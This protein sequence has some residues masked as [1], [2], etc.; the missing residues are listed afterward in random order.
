MNEQKVK[1]VVGPGVRTSVSRALSR[2]RYPLSYYANRYFE[3]KIDTF[4]P[5]YFLV[6]L[7]LDN[8]AT[9]SFPQNFPF[10][11]FS[12]RFKADEYI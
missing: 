10:K 6:L 9:C 1:I 7:R 12:I 2:A 8:F 3:A 11:V 4:K 5:S